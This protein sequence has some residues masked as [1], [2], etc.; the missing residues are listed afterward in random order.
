MTAMLAAGMTP[1][2]MATVL[3]AHALERQCQRVKIHMSHGQNKR[4]PI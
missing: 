3:L 1:L 4:R 2:K